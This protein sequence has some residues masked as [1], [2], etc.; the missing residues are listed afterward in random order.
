MCLEMIKL[1]GSRDKSFSIHQRSQNV[2]VVRTET[3]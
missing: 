3:E 1:I 2:H